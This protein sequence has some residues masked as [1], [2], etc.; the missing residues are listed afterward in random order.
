MLAKVS[1]QLFIAF[2]HINYSMLCSLEMDRVEKSHHENMK[3]YE[4]HQ[5][6]LRAALQCARGELNQHTNQSLFSTLGF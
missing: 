3:S 2:T 4:R 6:Q 1:S 5:D